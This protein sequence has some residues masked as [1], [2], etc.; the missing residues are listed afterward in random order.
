MILKLFAMRMTFFVI[1][2]FWGININTF[3]QITDKPRLLKYTTPL[4]PIDISK[5]FAKEGLLAANTETV[6]VKKDTIYTVL[7]SDMKQSNGYVILRQGT[8][9]PEERYDT[10]LLR[11][12]LISPGYAFNIIQNIGSYSLIQFFPLKHQKKKNL[13]GHILARKKAGEKLNSLDVESYTIQGLK[14]TLQTPGVDKTENIFD[15]SETVFIVPTS[16][17]LNNSYEFENQNGVFSIGLL[18]LPV[19]L[20]PFATESGQF[21]FTDGFSVGTTLSWTIHQNFKKGFAHS[22]LLYVGVSSF[23]ADSSKIKE[24]RNDYKI[25]TFSPAI[26]WMWGKNNVQLSLLVG[27]DFPPGQLQ[28]KWVYRNKP[29]L[30]LGIGIGLFKI[31]NDTNNQL[32]NNK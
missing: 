9:I 23:T 6:S 15:L 22:A 17:I 12:F 27:I 21:D 10:V 14:L 24:Q 7:K 3:A 29:W 28:K 20:R 4:C 16:L 8:E 25:A 13:F 1:L 11:T 26:G 2:F 5:T 31:G 30:G 18:A 32:G 19:K